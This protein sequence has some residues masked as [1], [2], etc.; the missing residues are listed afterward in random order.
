MGSRYSYDNG[1]RIGR[2]GKART[3]VSNGSEV[4]LPRGWLP[5]PMT[6]PLTYRVMSVL[7]DRVARDPRFDRLP[8]SREH[9]TSPFSSWRDSAD[10]GAFLILLPVLLDT[11][12][13]ADDCLVNRV[14]VNKCY[15]VAT[16][17]SIAHGSFHISLTD[18]P[19][20]SISLAV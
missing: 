6:E 16:V 12:T 14:T 10:S 15:I 8:C 17:S 9:Q 18:S 7:L 11:G 1:L 2:A 4:S 5:N 13:Y 3:E 20:L 19:M